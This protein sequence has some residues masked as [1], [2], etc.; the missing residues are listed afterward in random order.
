MSGLEVEGHAALM[1]PGATEN[2]RREDP[3]LQMDSP[4]HPRLASLDTDTAPRND[5]S[6]QV[7]IGCQRVWAKFYQLRFPS[8][9]ES[10]CS[11]TPA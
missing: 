10:L 11:I 6:S 7:L 1:M 9:T 2:S 8:E 3:S 5:L 4:Q